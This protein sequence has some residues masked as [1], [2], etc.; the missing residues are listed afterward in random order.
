VAKLHGDVSRRLFSGIWPD[1]PEHEIPITSV[2]NGV[3]AR[4]WT[5]SEMT[6]LYDKVIG[7]QWPEADPEAW[8]RIEVVSSREL[9]K[10]RRANRERLVAYARHQLRQAALNRGESESQAAWTDEALDPD[11]LTIGFARRFATYKRATLLFRE[12]DRLKALLL[13]ADRPIQILFAGKAHPADEPGHHLLQTVANVA[14]EYDVRHRLVLIE[15]YDITVA[16]MLVQG[17]DVW[18]NTPLRPN[19]ACGTSGMKAS[20]NG[21]LNCSVLDGWW[22]EMYEPDIGWAIPSV[23]GEVDIEARNAFESSSLFALLERQIVPL[24]YKRD[25]DGIPEGWLARVKRSIARL[26]PKVESTRMLREYVSDLYE[27]AAAHAERLEA[28][29][30]ERAKAL[31]RWKRHV[32][33]AWPSVSVTATSY[34]ELPTAQGTTY[35]VTAQ[36]S[37]G[38]LEHSDVEVQLLYGDVELDDDLRHPTTVAMTIDGEG[39]HPGW[40]R[41][42]HDLTF[43]RAGNFGFTVRIIPSHPDL[44]NF[45]VLGRVAW[46]SAPPGL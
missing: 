23:E 19:E 28:K 3:H 29:G 34:D 37:L 20:F 26:G 5:S 18:L 9:W 35:R 14:A 12:L 32:A 21:A 36:V 42:Q 2:T 8:K 44:S 39:D 24:F 13:D 38:E 46:A 30:Y 27:P 7:N 45:A 22:D 10:V 40:R 16:R 1:I 25:D 15:D 41:Y 31:V 4:T 6:K 43:D 17:V 33:R 11:V